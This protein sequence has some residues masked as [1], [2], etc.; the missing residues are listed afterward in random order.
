MLHEISRNLISSSIAV[1]G[2]LQQGFPS[3]HLFQS[4]LSRMCCDFVRDQDYVGVMLALKTLTLTLGLSHSESLIW[5]EADVGVLNLMESLSQLAISSFSKDA[6][7]SVHPILM[8]FLQKLCNFSSGVDVLLRKRVLLSLSMTAGD[9][10]ISPLFLQLLKFLHSL[11]S[12]PM[13]KELDNRGLS[14]LSVQSRE[15]VSSHFSLISES[16]LFQ[17]LESVSI[18]FGAD[19]CLAACS[20]VAQVMRSLFQSQVVLQDGWSNMFPELVKALKSHILLLSSLFCD[21]KRILNA[22]SPFFDTHALHSL[23]DVQY[24]LVS[25]H[26][27]REKK[28]YSQQEL[29]ETTPW[30]NIEIEL[31]MI[32]LDSLGAYRE[33]FMPRLKENLGTVFL[34][35]AKLE[36]F[37]LSSLSEFASLCC[38]VSTMLDSLLSGLPGIDAAG[39]DLKSDYKVFQLH[40]L[41]ET[42]LYVVVEHGIYFAKLPRESRKRAASTSSS[43][44]QIFSSSKKYDSSDALLILVVLWTF[45]CDSPRFGPP[46]H[47]HT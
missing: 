41:L 26:Y 47:V 10:D 43:L 8:F 37:E 11:L 20:Q 23:R 42:A 40:R 31:A 27:E 22:F 17:N 1:I 15:L 30:K 16:L 2:G 32:L 3:L 13:T 9:M 46:L 6:P 5:L 28:N 25:M 45:A 44:H 4:F 33:R 35:L 7:A 14:E 39:Q 24:S 36:P 34:P 29:S 12:S 38:K 19:Q 21:S 18:T